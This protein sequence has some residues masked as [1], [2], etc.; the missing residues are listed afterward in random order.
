MAVQTN[1]STG[2]PIERDVKRNVRGQIVSYTIPN[3]NDSTV[4]TPTYGKVYMD[5]G[6]DGKTFVERFSKASVQSN[7]DVSISELS[8]EF[9]SINSNVNV[10]GVVNYGS[11]IA[12][13]AGFNSTT[14]ASGTAAVGSP[15]GGGN[16]NAGGGYGSTGI[17]D[18][19]GGGYSYSYSSDS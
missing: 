10:R 17:V 7:L 13:A 11:A 16:P 12:F 3:P 6:E 5:N 2:T 1:T 19:S 9:P 14:N 15:G 4:D 8:F 18:Y